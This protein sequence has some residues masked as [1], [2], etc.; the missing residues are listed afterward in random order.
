[1][2]R[3]ILRQQWSYV[4][5]AGVVAACSS[6]SSGGVHEDPDGGGSQESDG[7]ATPSDASRAGDARQGSDAQT[8]DAAV[9]DA[10][11]ESGHDA[12][13]DSGHDADV[14]D[15]AMAI[16]AADAAMCS[17]PSTPMLRFRASPGVYCPF[18][19]GN[20]PMVCGAADECCEPPHVSG[21]ASSCQAKGTA[22]PVVGSAAWACEETLDCDGGKVCCAAGTLA[23]DPACGFLRG[24]VSLAAS[25]C[26]TSCGAGELHICASQAECTAGT[27]CTP[28][29]VKGLEL[30]ACL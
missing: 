17:N 23:L 14:S 25:A 27:V 5:I 12:A 4:M 30:G 7:G 21:S 29:K 24:S 20:M 10:T 11:L 8:M 3:T 18:G 1:M 22:C 9:D 13:P 19:P 15:S 6:S 26:A 16:D 2:V 28:F